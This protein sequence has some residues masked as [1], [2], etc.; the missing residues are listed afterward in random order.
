MRR[1]PPRNAAR[2]PV[3]I[4]GWIPP[5]E[6]DAW[7][8]D[9]REA[10]RAGRVIRC[11]CGAWIVVRE[12][13]SGPL[14]VDGVVHE[15]PA[16]VSVELEAANVAGPPHLVELARAF[17]VVA[18]EVEPASI[19]GFPIYRYTAPRRALVAFLEDQYEDGSGETG[20]ELL[21][22]LLTPNG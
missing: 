11:E 14:E 9:Y 1:R 3:D 13:L 20:G 5:A 16:L 19:I 12:S 6:F 2:L 18:R 7:A 15:C 22:R 10:R 4:A 21:E 8:R 17:G